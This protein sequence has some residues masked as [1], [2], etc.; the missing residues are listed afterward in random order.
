MLGYPALFTPEGNGF[1]ATFP[2]MLEAITDGGCEREAMEY[3]ADA[4]AAALSKYVKRRPDI[5]R[6]GKARGNRRGWCF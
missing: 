6:A 5:P 2:D 3:A 1:V 4:I